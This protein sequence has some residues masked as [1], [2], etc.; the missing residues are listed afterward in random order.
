VHV[1]G[2]DLAWGS[3]AWTG[4]A[5]VDAEGRLLVMDRVRTDDEIRDLAVAYLSGP[6]LVA[7]DAP[8][9][10]TNTVG[11]RHCEHLVSAAFGRFHAGAHPSNLS[12]PAFHHGP[13]GGRLAALL[14]LDVDPHFTART[15]VRRAI[16]V[17]PHPA[18][19][20]L[21]GLD[22]VL[23]Y[24]A[25]PGRTPQQRQAALTTLL[26]HVE[27]LQ[28]ATPPLHV[29][30]CCGWRSAVAAVSAAHTHAELNRWEDAVDAVL[31]AYIG[32]HRWWHGDS[33]SAVVGDVETGYIVV[34]VDDRTRPLLDGRK[35]RTPL[36][37]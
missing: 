12:L 13:R 17:Y 3:K 4:V 33:R 14:G 7:I 31:C 24:K 11:R 32:L 18:T 23:P 8:V 37:S 28:D 25:K 16:E 22:R 9:V 6:V 21:F 20:T 36:R 1:V 29:H 27:T 26:R 2:V 15:P 19:I 34:P 30:D 35:C 10:V 5:V